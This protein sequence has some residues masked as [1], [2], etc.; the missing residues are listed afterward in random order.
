MLNFGTT[1]ARKVVEVSMQKSRQHEFKR[2]S[3]IQIAGE[4]L[5]CNFGTTR[6]KK[7]DEVSL[8]RFWQHELN[9]ESFLQI[10][11]SS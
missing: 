9:P 11:D 6:T 1:R 5:Y 4:D 8:E 7:A 2:V 3:F 10:E